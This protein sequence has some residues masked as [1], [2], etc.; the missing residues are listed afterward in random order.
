M[1][2]HHV[3]LATLLASVAACASTQSAAPTAPTAAMRGDAARPAEAGGWVRS[4]L[5]FSV[6]D[7]DDPGS[8]IDEAHW[9]A[10]LDREVSP[11]FP[12][13]LTVL[14]GYGQWLFRGR[15]QAAATARQGAGGPAR[16]QRRAPRRHRSDP[17]GLEAG[18][19]PPVGAVVEPAGAGVV[20][21]AARGRASW[22]SRGCGERREDVSWRSSERSEGAGSAGTAWMRGMDSS[23][24]RNDSLLDVLACRLA[25]PAGPAGRPCRWALPVGS[26]GRQLPEFPR[27]AGCAGSRA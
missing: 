26:A 20:L 3:L 6:G 21:G 2:W 4:E 5:Y 11:R 23:R 17:P 10:F 14:D 27:A 19:R 13:G 25:A 12:D 24:A 7:E 18:H 22:V 8:A 15:G 1:P 9:R 16:R